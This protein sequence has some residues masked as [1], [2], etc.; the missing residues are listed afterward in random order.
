M[1][2]TGDDDIA[3]KVE[4]VLVR[5]LGEVGRFLMAQ[6]LQSIGKSP[7]ELTR[8]DLESFIEGIKTDFEKVIGYG[9]NQLEDDLK[10]CL[11]EE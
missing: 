2:A 3:S 1:A 9:V 7:D 4:E 8:E 6:Q 10:A 5:N 11:K